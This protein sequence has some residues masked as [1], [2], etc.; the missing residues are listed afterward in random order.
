MPSVD[1]IRRTSRPREIQYTRDGDPSATEGHGPFE[2]LIAA[3]KGSTRPFW[4]ALTTSS[5]SPLT[6]AT[7][8][9][10]TTAGAEG[11]S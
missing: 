11:P 9:D 5:S 8:N 10:P 1:T 3:A 6:T 7:P 2:G 4:N